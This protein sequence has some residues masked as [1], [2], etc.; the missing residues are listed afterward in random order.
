M[1][2]GENKPRPR[3][4][5]AILNRNFESTGGGAERYS[6][7]MVE[8]LA[9]R[10]DIHVFAQTIDHER[11]GVTYHK[12]PKLLVRPRWVNQVCYAASTW[13]STRRGFDVVHSHENTWHGQVQTVHVLPLRHTLFGTLS[14]LGL[15]LRWLKVLTSPRLIAYLL[16]EHLRFAPQPDRRIIA[17][18]P[19]LHR[20]MARTYPDS[21]SMLETIAPGVAT[22]AGASNSDAKD[23][24]RASLGL[25]LQ[26]H[27]V[28]FVGN[29]YRKKGLS[30]LLQSLSQLP[31][32][33][34]LAVVGNPAYIAEFKQVASTHGVAD[35]V[36]FLG[37]LKEID[38]AY[39]AA[40]CLAHPTLQDTFAMVVL[41]AMAHGLPVVVSA[42]NYCGI[43]GLLV[44]GV[45]ALILHEP[46]DAS[47]LTQL[48]QAVLF[49]PALGQRLGLAATQ[50][51]R[52][53]SWQSLALRQ[54]AIYNEVRSA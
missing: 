6:I 25:P 23:K 3:L 35:R 9:K 51:C 45:N 15:A 50:F 33:V 26:G 22:V 34:F 54:E 39:V 14:G 20:L 29:D 19:S 37:A 5:I 36:Y 43:S 44:D 46:G 30:T 31:A 32:E 49:E 4:R 18:S 52:S 13:W 24:A 41:E 21:A 16:L 38:H 28:L 2:S 42:E 11:P 40:T 17:T 1:M 48:L 47:A 27:C 7:A 53:Y 8:E 10:H 12:V